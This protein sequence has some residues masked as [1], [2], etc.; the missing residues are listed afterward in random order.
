M[1][2]VLSSSETSVLT[3]ATRRNI[4]EDAI[5]H[6]HLRKNLKSYT[7]LLDCGWF[8][9]KILTDKINSLI[10]YYIFSTI[11]VHPVICLKI[12][13]VIFLHKTYFS[14]KLI[15]MLASSSRCLLRWCSICHWCVLNAPEE[16]LRGSYSCLCLLVPKIYMFVTLEYWYSCHNSVH[17]LFSVLYLKRYKSQEDE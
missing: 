16:M 17:Y 6:S 7:I 2:E 13:H 15:A 5:L 1:K 4:P 3:R 8:I 12:F 9:E 11:R 14:I 10:Y